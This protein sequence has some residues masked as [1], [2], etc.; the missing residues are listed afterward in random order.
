MCVRCDLESWLGSTS[1]CHGIVRYASHSSGRCLYI[2]LCR[3]CFCFVLLLGLVPLLHYFLFG[4][5][6]LFSSVPRSLLHPFPLLCLHRCYIGAT[7]VLTSVRTSALQRSLDRD[8]ISVTSARYRCYNSVYHDIFTGVHTTV[9]SV[10]TFM[11]YFP[12][13]YPF[14][15]HKTISTTLA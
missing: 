10:D 15:T 4:F 13:T 5:S 1:G 6:S 8:Y 9:T 12:N 2:A 7:S 3:M 11:S 14:S